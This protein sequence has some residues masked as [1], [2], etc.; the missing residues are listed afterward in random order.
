MLIS[1]SGLDGAGKTTL[2]AKAKEILE[3]GGRKV[4]IMTMYDN[5]SFSAFLRNRVIR[6]NKNFRNPSVRSDGQSYRLD[7]NRQDSR[8]VSLR[9]LVYV[10]D[11]IIFL[12]LR[13]Y[14]QRIKKKYTDYGQVFL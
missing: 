12:S 10:V 11:L 1:F 2:I 13:V 4:K 9:Q 8:T 5:V 6:R 7:K 3:R 14:Y